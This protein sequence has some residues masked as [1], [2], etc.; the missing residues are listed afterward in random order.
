VLKAAQD[1]ALLDK[2]KKEVYCGSCSGFKRTA[3]KKSQQ[4]P[5]C[6][7]F[8]FLSCIFH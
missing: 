4:V 1:H 3:Y 6:W 5:A 2:Q 8:C 7:L